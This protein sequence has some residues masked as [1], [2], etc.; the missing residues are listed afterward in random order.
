MRPQTVA[1]HILLK[2]RLCSKLTVYNTERGLYSFGAGWIF[3][4]G[5]PAATRRQI[6]KR[7]LRMRMTDQMRGIMSDRGCAS[8]PPDIDAD[9]VGMA[10]LFLV[11][12]SLL[13][14]TIIM[15]VV[16]HKKGG[17]EA[18]DDWVHILRS[19]VSDVPVR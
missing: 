17:P 4:K 16:Q 6:D 10:A 9:I 19:R 18:R 14:L 13:L 1:N 15:C 2:R 5:V 12:P 11:A 3:G 7:I 8:P